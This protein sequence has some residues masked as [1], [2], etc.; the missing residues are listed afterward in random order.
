DGERTRETARKSEKKC[1]T[2]EKLPVVVR[3]TRLDRRPQYYRAREH[4]LRLV[5]IFLFANFAQRNGTRCREF[6]LV[7]ATRIESTSSTVFSSLV[8]CSGLVLV[9]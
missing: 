5:K 3:I 4:H 7:V 2:F 8:G 9:S 6:P 1:L